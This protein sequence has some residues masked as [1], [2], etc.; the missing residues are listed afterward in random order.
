MP[1]PLET[2][3]KRLFCNSFSTAALSPRSLIFSMSASVGTIH[4]PLLLFITMASNCLIFSGR[5]ICRSSL[6][7]GLKAP[8]FSPRTFIAASP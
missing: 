7:T 8:V 3:S 4:G 2:K 5:Y 6:M 1:P